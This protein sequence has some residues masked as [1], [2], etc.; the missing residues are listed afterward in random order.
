M[1]IMI[2]FVNTRIRGIAIR[3]IKFALYFVIQIKINNAL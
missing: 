1:I 3:T 2:P